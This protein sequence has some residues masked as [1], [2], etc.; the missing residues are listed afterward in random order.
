MFATFHAIQKA[1]GIVPKNRDGYYGLHDLR[2]GFATL[3]AD[4]MD[5][6]QLRDLMQHKSLKTTE[7][8][9][10]MARRLQQPVD[11]HVSFTS[12]ARKEAVLLGVG[13]LTI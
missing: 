2:R 13:F 5:L 3:N 12:R 6:F 9:V 7:I 11:H 8:Y 4:K 10:Q 1:A